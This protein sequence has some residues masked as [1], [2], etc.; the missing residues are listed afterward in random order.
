MWPAGRGTEFWRRL[1]MAPSNTIMV[2][3]GAAD[4]RAV[5][6]TQPEDLKYDPANPA[7]GLGGHFD[8]EFLAVFADGSVRYLQL[9]ID[10][11]TLRHVFTAAGGEPV[12]LP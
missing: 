8:K 6:W 9:D 2:V 1:P 5:V 12:K 11:D 4:D 10:A 3:G 7:A